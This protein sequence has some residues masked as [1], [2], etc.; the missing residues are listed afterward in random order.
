MVSCL[1]TI[2]DVVFT[3]D[4]IYEENNQRRDGCIIKVQW[5]KYNDSPSHLS[6]TAVRGRTPVEISARS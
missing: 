2:E 4:S 1:S 5:R 3:V 6:T